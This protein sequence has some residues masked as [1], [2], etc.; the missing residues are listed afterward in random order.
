[1]SLCQDVSVVWLAAS[2]DM[3]LVV[4]S[5]P[6]VCRTCRINW[7]SGPNRTRLDVFPPCG[8]PVFWH[9]NLEHK[10]LFQSD[11][12]GQQGPHSE[13]KTRPSPLT[14]K[15]QL[16]TKV[17]RTVPSPSHRRRLTLDCFYEVSVVCTQYSKRS[18]GPVS[19]STTKEPSG[20]MFTCCVLTVI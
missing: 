17:F 9:T 19:S 4:V 10:A 20:Q 8:F 13:G 11:G 6:S 16:S 15:S 12:W 7:A 1:M 3:L 5:S 18:V 14:W 2:V